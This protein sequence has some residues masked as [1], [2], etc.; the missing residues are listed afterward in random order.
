MGNLSY[1]DSA[2]AMFGLTLLLFY[3]VPAI[4]YIVKRVVSFYYAK[5]K[6]N[7]ATVRANTVA[8][9]RSQA[10]QNKLRV[11]A[12]ASTKPD[13]LL[14]PGFRILCIV[15]AIAILV[16]IILAL[17]ARHQ[18]GLAQYDPYAVCYWI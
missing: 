7:A 15:T 1:D 12:T 14:T 4:W 17:Q 6:A 5:S 8:S 10:E 11:Y 18:S 16:F 13:V 9:A 2:A 3:L